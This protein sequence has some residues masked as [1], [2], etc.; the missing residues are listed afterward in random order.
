MGGWKGFL[1][2]VTVRL[3]AGAVLG[4]GASALLGYRTILRALAHDDP[5]SVVLRL[6]VWGGIG[7]LICAC[8]T[9]RYSWPWRNGGDK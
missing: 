4:C 7:A 5:G 2:A 3:V 1:I 9:P 8:T 6:A